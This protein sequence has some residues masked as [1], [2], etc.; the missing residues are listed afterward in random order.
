MTRAALDALSPAE[1][2]KVRWSVYARALQPVIA[3]DFDEQ[4]EDLNDAD[5]PPSKATLKHRRAVQREKIAQA[6]V[7]QAQLREVLL[8]DHEGDE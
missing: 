5:S 6:R 4:L 1:A 2:L 7:Q 8:L 3:M